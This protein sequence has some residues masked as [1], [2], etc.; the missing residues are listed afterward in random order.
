MDAM[1]ENR[2]ESEDQ[3]AVANFLDLTK[4]LWMHTPNGGKRDKVTAAILK[5]MG[6]KAGVPDF[7][8]FD[9][10]K[11]WRPG[12]A[13]E[14]KRLK[15]GKMSDDQ[16]RWAKLFIERK[17]LYYKCDGSQDA[18]DIIKRLYGV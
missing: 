8:I 5:R 14:L 16:I 2:P 7:L 13:I 3:I 12:T 18:I 1:I 6:V 4:L 10:P 15:G 9:P 17:W 11:P